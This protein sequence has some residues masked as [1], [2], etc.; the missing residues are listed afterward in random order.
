M[1]EFENNPNFEEAERLRQ[2]LKSKGL[3]DLEITE[4]ILKLY[5]TKG[6]FTEMQGEPDFLYEAE[7]EKLGRPLTYDEKEKIK[8]D[9]HEAM[10]GIEKHLGLDDD[11]K[12]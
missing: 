2:E 6:M 1:A 10:K 4:L 8:N 7:E 11:T 3:T 9:L 5:G 12:H